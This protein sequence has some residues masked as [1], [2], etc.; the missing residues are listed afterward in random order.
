MLRLSQKDKKNCNFEESQTV[1]ALKKSNVCC[2]S[3]RENSENS[4]NQYISSKRELVET[5][6]K[7]ER[8]PNQVS[9]K[10]VTRSLTEKIMR[11]ESEA[12]YVEEHSQS[13]MNTKKPKAQCI[14]SCR[15]GFT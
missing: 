6:G 8:L 15:M 4:K 13:F 14:V 9:E 7:T 5:F 11:P 3:T 1:S 10:Q 12:F 2:F